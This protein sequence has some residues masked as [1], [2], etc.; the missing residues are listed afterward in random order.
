[1]LISRGTQ[2]LRF[3]K[4]LKS[5]SNINTFS[6][7]GAHVAWNYRTPSPAQPKI[8][9]TLA[10][11]TQGVMWWWILW[12]LWTQYDHIIGEFDYPD[13]SKWTDE[14]LGIPSEE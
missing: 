3:S 10:E 6:R 9:Y 8:I 7:N 13:P 4:I 1:M 14:E 2:F 12:H 11:V 5:N